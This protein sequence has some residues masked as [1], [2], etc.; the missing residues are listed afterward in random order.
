[1]SVVLQGDTHFGAALVGQF[2]EMHRAGRIHFAVTHRAPSDQLV[3][4]FIDDL[5]LPLEVDPEGSVRNPARGPLVNFFDALQVLHKSAEVLQ[6]APE[7]PEGGGIAVDD[8]ALL[9]FDAMAGADASSWADG[10]CRADSQRLIGGA[11]AGRSS[12]DQ[13]AAHSSQGQ[14]SEERR[15]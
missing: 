3:F 13:R 8:D 10:V 1:M 9:N 7:A 12:I 15:V 11:M 6:L 14:R 2:A 4:A 5:G